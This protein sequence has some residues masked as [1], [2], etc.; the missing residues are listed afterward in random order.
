MMKT[1]LYKILVCSSLLFVI[2][3]CES[4]NQDDYEE[5]VVVEGYV[6]AGER[7]PDIFVS[8]TLPSDSTYNFDDSL[9]RN[10]I[11][12]VT[13]LDED[14][15][16]V[17]VFEYAENLERPGTY[18]PIIQSYRAE[19]LTTYRLDVVFEDRPEQIRAF[20]TVPDQVQVIND[21]PESVVYQSEEQLEI[22]LDPLQQTSDGQSVFVFNTISLDPAIESLTPFYLSVVEDDE[23]VDISEYVRNSSGLINE[24]NFD[25]QPDGTILLRFPWIG[26]AFYGENLVVTLAVDKNLA[27]VIRSQEVQLGGS[28][29]SPGEIPNLLYNI[30]G[31]IGVFGS[32]TADT[33]QTSFSRP[34]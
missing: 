5:Y 17:E 28:T 7:L 15:D 12:Q 10:A 23:D 4:Y 2:S 6:T 19:P 9:I 24:G 14:G 31:G 29:L 1:F 27:D 18:S 25:P 26:V 3:S 13:L 16:P 8:T 22:I 33:I 34:F 11:V 32:M 20:T 21:I 30:E